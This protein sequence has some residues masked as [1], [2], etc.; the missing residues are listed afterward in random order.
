MT[1]SVWEVIS[2][3]KTNP[4]VTVFTVKKDCNGLKTTNQPNQTNLKK[5]KLKEQNEIPKGDLGRAKTKQWTGPT[6]RAKLGGFV[7]EEGPL[8]RMWLESVCGRAGAAPSAP[9]LPTAPARRGDWLPSLPGR[10]DPLRA[11]GGICL[12][13]ERGFRFFILF[14]L[15]Y[16]LRT[17]NAKPPFIP[18]GS[19]EGATGEDNNI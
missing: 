14:F 6:W 1:K 19:Y 11:A 17:W 7:A 10:G 3:S 18:S 8:G 4:K 5:I 9:R 12:P 13:G 2:F 16:K 15:F